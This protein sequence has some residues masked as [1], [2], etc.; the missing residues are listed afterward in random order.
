MK[1]VEIRLPRDFEEALAVA[2]PY[3]TAALSFSFF[4]NLLYLAPSI[5]MLQIY[6]RV[7]PTGGK[8]TLLFVTIA[9][10]VALGAMALLDLVR[11]RL[12][13][14]ASARFDS[15][16]ADKILK[17]SMAGH[18]SLGS[19]QAMRDFDTLRNAMASPAAGA[20]LDVPWAPIYIIV[21]FLFHFWLGIF[22]VFS[23]ALLLVIAWRN[24]KATRSAVERSNQAFSAAH[25][26]QQS[27]ALHGEVIRALGMTGAMVQRQQ[28]Q[29]AVAL[30]DSIG[31]QITGGQ[32]TAL[33]KFTRMFVQSCALGLGALLAVAGEISNGSIIAASILLSRALQP[34]EAVISGWGTIANG[35]A[36]ADRLF[37]FYERAGEAERIRTSLPP[38]EGRIE[39]EQVGL[40][41][42]GGQ[43]ILFGISLTLEPGEVLGVIG[44]SGAGKTSLAKLVCGAL[45]PD[46]GT[47]RIDGA[48][49]SDWDQ[50]KLC[51]HIGYLPQEP[52]LFE[53]TVKDNISRFTA[54][55]DSADGDTDDKAIAAAKAAG[56]HELILHLPQGYDTF[57]G[58]MTG[59]L[60]AGQAQRVALARA[61]Y[62][63]PAILV[64]DEPNSFLDADG[65]AALM[66]AMTAARG[67]RAAI[68]VAAHRKTILTCA[69]R[70]LVL[71]AG[72]M[73]LLGP[74]REV[75]ARLAGPAE[76]T[77]SA[78]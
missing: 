54:W 67:R 12:L 48:Q 14:R 9:L 10:A 29:R 23:I 62:D 73:K 6:D 16:L 57:L 74:T 65:E 38:P 15:L 28:M 50:D 49:F 25:A 31:A 60:S 34:A 75:A 61:L 17:R 69:D 33:T 56:V 66:S 40:R 19:T 37:D 44:P 3:F 18:G 35:K 11:N 52:S 32:F 4:I 72:R 76:R 1:V 47:I 68:M 30:R 71:D 8:I 51:R 20:M 46:A 42:S 22:A 43:P 41:G 27:A 58:P 21:A 64:L 70:L 78:A 53:G 39:V 2:K 77:E 59:G 36:A 63:N 13:V 55:G 24:Q 5:Y 45:A 26:A 7:V